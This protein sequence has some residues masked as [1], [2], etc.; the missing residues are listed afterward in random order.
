MVSIA[1]ATLEPAQAAKNGA[2]RD[3]AVDWTAWD[4]YEPPGEDV[5]H[6]FCHAATENQLAHQ[7]E[8]RDGD[9]DEVGAAFPSPVPHDVPEVRVGDVEELHE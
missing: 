2:V 4:E 8:E 3:I 1:I 9:E 6:S 5:V 7:D